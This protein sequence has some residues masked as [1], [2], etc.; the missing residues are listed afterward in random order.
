MV[1]FCLSV[2]AVN[3]DNRRYNYGSHTR[4]FLSKKKYLCESHVSLLA[5]DKSEARAINY[6][7]WAV[8]FCLFQVLKPNARTDIHRGIVIVIRK[9]VRLW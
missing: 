9:G 5:S 1:S 6:I 3:G 8:L 2:V 4:G 7:V